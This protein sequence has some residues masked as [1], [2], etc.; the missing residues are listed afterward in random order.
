MRVS[1]CSQR[2]MNS[3]L[4]PSFCLL[5]DLLSKITVYTL[6]YPGVCEGSARAHPR[7]SM[8][9]TV[10]SA[11]FWLIFYLISSFSTL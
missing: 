1:L 4:Q 11:C 5:A 7:G 10:K 6:V 2:H 3:Q 9:K 8:A